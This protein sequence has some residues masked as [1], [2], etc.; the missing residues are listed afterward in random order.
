MRN[1]I[2]YALFFIPGILMW[3]MEVKYFYQWWGGVGLFLGLFV[4]PLAAF[5]P[6][7][8]WVVTGIFPLMYFIFWGISFLGVIVIKNENE[9]DV[10]VN[11]KTKIANAEAQTKNNWAV[12]GFILGVLS[13][14]FA[15]IG[16]IPLSG[17]VI[18]IVGIIKARKR[19]GKGKWLAMIGLILSSLYTLV[20]LNRYG[21]L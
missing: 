11:T 21:Y 12:V 10:I 5:F 19:G 16:I 6:V 18:N 15:W 4:P 8:F 13:I 20:Y 14:F 9:D 17:L 7:I 1:V 3:L 2:G